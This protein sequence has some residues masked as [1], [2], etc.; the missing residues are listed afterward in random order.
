M[1]S[2]LSLILAG[3]L[4]AAAA[5]ADPIK[6]TV[7]VNKEKVGTLVSETTGDDDSGYVDDSTMTMTHE[8]KSVSFHELVHYGKDGIAT[9]RSMEIT[10]GDADV[11]IKATLSD[12]GAKVS[13]W[14]GDQK[15]EKEVPLSTKTSRVDATNFWF[16]KDKPALGDTVTYQAFDL[17]EMKW[18]DVKLKFVGKAKVKIGDTEIEENEIDR[19]EGE[20]TTQIYVDEKGDA[21]LILDGEMRIERKM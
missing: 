8:D 5:W 9:S 4:L 14:D 15:E 3:L 13:L 6:Y 17:Q 16:K 10:G 19:T 20:E 7:F 2:R 12:D 11:K 1:N 21:V 18:S